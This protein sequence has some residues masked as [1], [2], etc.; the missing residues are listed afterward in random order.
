MRLPS[1]P[2][3]SSWGCREGDCGSRGGRRKT[4]TSAD[5][6]SDRWVQTV[7]YP[8]PGA[9]QLAAS[10]PCAWGGLTRGSVRAYQGQCT[11]AGPA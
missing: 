6:S 11:Q 9:G 3:L 10:R 1:C 7:T 4:A 2:D 5:A 8:V